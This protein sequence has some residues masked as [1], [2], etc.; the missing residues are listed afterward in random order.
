MFI[1]AKPNSLSIVMVVC[2][3][4]LTSFKA[5]PFSRLLSA[6]MTGI[7][8]AIRSKQLMLRKMSVKQKCICFLWRKRFSSIEQ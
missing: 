2:K 1:I 8:Q 4:P 5:A 3:Y 7:V 6:E